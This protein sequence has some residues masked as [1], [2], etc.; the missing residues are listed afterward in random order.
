[1]Y[2][3]KL[4]SSST[5]NN[6]VKFVLLRSTVFV[7]DYNENQAMNL[8]LERIPKISQLQF[9]ASLHDWNRSDPHMWHP[10][11]LNRSSWPSIVE[12]KL[13]KTV[14]YNDADGGDAARWGPV[15]G[16]TA[17]WRAAAATAG[18]EW[19]DGQAVM[20]NSNARWN[21]SGQFKDYWKYCNHICMN[22]RLNSEYYLK[23]AFKVWIFI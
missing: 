2:I 9:A 14:K 19:Y 20:V 18:C 12:W 5:V 13:A 10:V 8:K 1:M 4:W 3:L 6:V 11:P 15:R 7:F 21:G 23:D 22:L 16:T 17:R